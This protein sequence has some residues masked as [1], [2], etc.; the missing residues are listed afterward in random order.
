ML[1][2][3]P[4]YSGDN[5]LSIAMR[6]LNDPVPSV[7]D[8]RPDVPLRIDA[9]VSRAMAKDPSDRFASMDDFVQ[10]LEV[11]LADLGTGIDSDRTVILP[12]EAVRA[13]R[14]RRM[15]ARRR[16]APLYALVFGLAAIAG[17]VGAY[18]LLS[19]DGGSAKGGTTQSTG[20]IVV[21]ATATYDPPPGDG[22]EHDERIPFATDGDETTYWETERY[23]SGLAGTG[24]EGVGLVLDAHRPVDARRLTV[25]SDTPGYTAE[26]RAG[27]SPSGPFE[28]VGAAQVGTRETRWHLEADGPK[29]YYVIWITQLAPGY[30]R[31]FVNEASAG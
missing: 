9:A 2:G 4:P 30:P 8:A 3:K 14:P 17:A 16:R 1:A 11:C 22:Q 28:T 6:H 10:E 25:T 24:K 15:R 20:P 29:Q 21:A 18:L 12:G 19:G 26:I 31:T 27:D 5:F 13:S 7:V 23:S